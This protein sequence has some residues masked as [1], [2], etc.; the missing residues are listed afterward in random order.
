MLQGE[1][2]RLALQEIVE[3]ADTA[4]AIQFFQDT[5]QTVFHVYDMQ[6][7]FR[8]GVELF[9]RAAHRLLRT[10]SPEAAGIV[11]YKL[12]VRRG[13]FLFHL[14]Q[15][16]E[17]QQL[18]PK[19]LDHLQANGSPADTLFSR[20]Y[21]AAVLHHSGQWDSAAK[22]AQESLHL[23]AKLGNR[24]AQA[25]IQYEESLQIRQSMNDLRDIAICLNLLGECAEAQA[26]VA[27]ARQFYQ[28][29]RD[30]FIEINNA[31]S[32][33]LVERN[34]SRLATVGSQ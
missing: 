33:A 5:L 6:S 3:A 8:E 28:Q 30:I 29:S 21:L 19:S 15:R 11:G 34:L 18:L 32:L 4:V 27:Q 7:W 25:T 16:A 26:K 1:R 24:Y 2:Q 14:G 13:W 31:Q 23:A 22:L 9:Q 12:L 10:P 20:S 17:A